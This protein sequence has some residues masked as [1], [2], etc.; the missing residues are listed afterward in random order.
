MPGLPGAGHGEL[1]GL[2]PGL[3]ATT[4]ED[5]SVYAEYPI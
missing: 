3:E 2:E 4:L 1:V 5:S